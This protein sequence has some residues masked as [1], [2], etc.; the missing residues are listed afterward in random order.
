MIRS[1]LAGHPPF[2]SSP[3]RP[4]DDV[5]RVGLALLTLPLAAA[6]GA[7]LCFPS[8]S[9]AIAAYQHGAVAANAPIRCQ[10]APAHLL[11]TTVGRL[12]LADGLSGALCLAVVTRPLDRRT[13]RR[14]AEEHPEQ[15]WDAIEARWRP[16]AADALAASGL[17]LSARDL[18]PPA[19]RADLQARAWTDHREIEA[20]W[21]EGLITDEEL[22]LKLMDVWWGFAADVR[23]ALVERLRRDASPD[24]FRRGLPALLQAAQATRATRGLTAC[25]V[26]PGI[27]SPTSPDAS[28]PILT[29]LI[30]GRSPHDAF[31]LAQEAARDRQHHAQQR[32]RCLPALQALAERLADVAV[33]RRDCRPLRG[34]VMRLHADRDALVG[35]VPLRPL[36]DP[37]SGGSLVE[38]DAPL[39][40]GALER[41]E[42]SGVAQLEVRWP[43]GCRALDGVCALCYG[44]APWGWGLPEVGDPVGRRAAAAFREAVLQAPRRVDRSPTR[45]P[46][47]ARAMFTARVRYDQLTVVPDPSDEQGALVATSA[48]GA[49]VLERLSTGWEV[50]HLV[51]RGARILAAAGAE[52]A[53]GDVVATWTPGELRLVAPLP[54]GASA[55]VDLRD[56]VRGVTVVSEISPWTGLSNHK[57]RDALDAELDPQIVLRPLDAELP[58][59]TLS[60]SPGMLLAV[61]SGE[62]VRAG[63]LLARRP[64]ERRSPLEPPGEAANAWCDWSVAFVQT[65]Q[66]REPRATASL[67]PV[68]GVVRLQRGR[69]GRLVTLYPD[70]GDP[71]TYRVGSAQPRVRSGER[72]RAGTLLSDGAPSCRDV[73]HHVGPHDAARLLVDNLLD[74]L[75]GAWWLRLHA[76]VIARHMLGCVEVRRG[77]G[78]GLAVGA[79]LPRGAFVAANRAALARGDEPAVGQG[80]VVSAVDG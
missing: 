33:T 19:E 13:L 32:L 30:E 69:G 48:D 42:R 72:V 2:A 61:W 50:A 6:H 28:A 70:E 20:M 46:S 44:H 58:P 67:A 26:P 16:I 57:V 59:I 34:V 8:P 73:L 74:G 66:G 11:D 35:R 55:V 43:P 39:T 37:R 1:D 38:A 64:A 5:T 76:E 25:S 14:L 63:Q 41:L 49:L 79:I 75:H 9:R 45:Q 51:P 36:R 52:V 18:A 65:L 29:T 23:R 31:R 27:V 54:S 24:A 40:L 78:T 4:L 17:S 12:Q 21:S 22:L 47:M 77:G 10:F 71:I 62:V 80:V 3:P 68:D 53:A 56:L 15:P 60:L 7:G